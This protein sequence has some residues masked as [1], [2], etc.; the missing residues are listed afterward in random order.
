M[1]D[2]NLNV[3][4]N[5][6]LKEDSDKLFK[7]LGLNMSS[8]INIFLTKCVNTSSIPF[9]IEIEKPNNNLIHALEEA[10]YIEKHPK[11]FKGY[12]NVDELFEVLESDSEYKKS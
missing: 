1:N 8:A 2:V 5:S 7:E 4:I 6:K 10:D 11:E 9:A 12:N 3:R